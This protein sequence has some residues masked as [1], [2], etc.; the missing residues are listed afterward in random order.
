MCF[1]LLL[2]FCG[3]ESYGTTKIKK[4]LTWDLVEFIWIFY[5]VSIPADQAKFVEGANVPG[6]WGDQTNVVVVFKL[7]LN[8]D[9]TDE[10]SIIDYVSKTLK[11]TDSPC[12]KTTKN[13]SYDRYGGRMDY[14]FDMNS[15]ASEVSFRVEKDH[16]LI[17]V[18]G[19]DAGQKFS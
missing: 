9:C 18:V 15:S 7:P 10:E 6:A 5:G 3:C 14:R 17:R 13:S 16:Y 2:S 1:A 11:L 12:Y 19:Y 4:G 8:P